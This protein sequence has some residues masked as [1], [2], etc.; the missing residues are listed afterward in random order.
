MKYAFKVTMKS[1][2]CTIVL[3]NI[4]VLYYYIRL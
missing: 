4:A 2:K 3:Q 1:S